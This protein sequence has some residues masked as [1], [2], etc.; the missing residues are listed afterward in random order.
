MVPLGHG[1]PSSTVQQPEIAQDD[2]KLSSQRGSLK[3]KLM[4][5]V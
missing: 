4:G 5:S 2:K 3:N 1:Q